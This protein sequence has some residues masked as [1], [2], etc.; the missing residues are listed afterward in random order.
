MLFKFNKLQ[1]K[2]INYYPYEFVEDNIIDVITEP[3]ESINSTHYPNSKVKSLCMNFNNKNLVFRVK[4]STNNSWSKYYYSGEII[5]FNENDKIVGI[6]VGYSDFINIEEVKT[7]CN[8]MVSL[9]Y[10]NFEQLNN[11]EKNQK[12]SII[13]SYNLF[14]DSDFNPNVETLLARPDLMVKVVSLASTVEKS[15]LQH[16]RELITRRLLNI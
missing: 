3:G 5:E 2:I 7:C 1:L 13:N 11:L 10:M 4:L 8:D 16:V 14:L 12:K 9:C 15:E 6:Q